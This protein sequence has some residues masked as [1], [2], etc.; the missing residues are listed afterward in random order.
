MARFRPY[1]LVP[2]GLVNLRE[3]GLVGVMSGVTQLILA[4]FLQSALI[5]LL[6]LAWTY[7]ALMSVEFFA[8]D[9]L[10]AR[11]ITYMWTHMLIVPL[12]DYYATACDWP[13]NGEA[14]PNV[15]AHARIA[16][17]ARVLQPAELVSRVGDAARLQTQSPIYGADAGLITRI[18]FSRFA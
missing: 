7:L 3:L 12:V 17:W 11:P 16:V 6:L 15:Q 8:R 4:A 1:R 9:W 14:Q 5:A 10:K 18:L 13:A 2:R